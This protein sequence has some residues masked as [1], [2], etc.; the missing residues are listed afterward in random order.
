MIAHR[1]P[2]GE[3]ARDYYNLGCKITLTFVPFTDTGKTLSSGTGMPS[4]TFRYA[5]DCRTGVFEIDSMSVYVDFDLAQ[6]VLEMKE[7]KIGRRPGRRHY[8]R[9][10]HA[11]ADQARA[12]VHLSRADHG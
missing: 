8:P 6:D 7:Q 10:H 9:P 3:Y 4:K 1:L 2:T 12:G 5:D 11:G